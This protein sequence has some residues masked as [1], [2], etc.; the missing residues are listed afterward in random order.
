M[1][2]VTIIGKMSGDCE[3]FCFDVEDKEEYIKIV[4]K[5][6]Y[7][8]EMKYRKEYWNKDKQNSAWRIY[9]TELLEKAG[10]N[11]DYKG[12]IKLTITAEKID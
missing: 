2:E 12:K 5:R 11:H 4:G 10:I 1:K 8:R 7:N 9:P 6:E 3:C